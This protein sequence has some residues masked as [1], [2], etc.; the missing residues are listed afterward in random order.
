MIGGEAEATQI[1]ARCSSFDGS[2]RRDCA[3]GLALGPAGRWRAARAAMSRLGAPLRVPVT[4]GGEAR[5]A[6]RG[7]AWISR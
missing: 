2:R 5:L 3:Y 6:G 4:T 1:P 7:T